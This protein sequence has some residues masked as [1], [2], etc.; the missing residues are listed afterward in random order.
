MP[1]PTKTRAEV[2]AHIFAVFRDRGFEGATLSEISQATG[3]G[4]SSLYHYF[5]NGKE[6]MVFAVFTL[7]ERW[8]T[9]NVLGPLY[10]VGTPK[11]KL[12]AM[13]RAFDELYDGGRNACVLGA[14]V[15]GGGRMRF[16]TELKSSFETWINALR[17]LAIEAG[18][19]RREAQQRAEDAVVRFEGALI[20]SGGLGDSGPFKRAA[21]QVERDLLVA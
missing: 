20:L 2:I 5:P 6:D 18:V 21:R 12:S 15:S 17:D 7:L 8:M 9:D 13:L 4:K 11:Q 3:L 10:G 14:L 16:Q 1:A 19:P